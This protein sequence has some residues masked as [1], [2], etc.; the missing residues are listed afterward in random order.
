[1]SFEQKSTRM[2]AK[3]KLLPAFLLLLVVQAAQ[4]QEPGRIAGVVAAARSNE[5]LSGVT[6]VVVGTLYA[7]VTD[8]AGR[9]DVGPVPPGR[10]TVQV[11]ALGFRTEAQVV[12][13]AAGAQAV[14]DF[15]LRLPEVTPEDI[16]TV[17]LQ[18]GLLPL[19]GVDLRRIR[20]VNA[21]DAGYLLRLLHG[22]GAGRR[23]AI[24]LHPSIRGLA[25]NQIGLYVDGARLLP[26]SPVGLGAPL[27]FFDPRGLESV[28]AV[29]GPYALTW[30]AGNLGALW[31]ETRGEDPVA[32]PRASLT[33]GYTSNLDALDLAGAASGGLGLL[34]YWLQGVLRTGDD[35]RDGKGRRVPADF[36]AT[37]VRGRLGFRLAP[38]ARLGVTAGYQGRQHVDAPGRLLDARSAAAANVSARFRSGWSAGLLRALDATLYWNRLA[39]DLDN[40]NTPLG[41]TVRLLLD[42][43]HTQAG[44]RLAAHLAPAEGWWLEAG[45]DAYSARY[46]ATLRLPLRGD[47]TRRVLPDARLATLGVFLGGTRTFGRVE[48]AVTARL[49]VVRAA[50]E[51]FGDDDEAGFSAA[52]SLAARLS[53]IW[54]VSVGV[55]SAVRTADA[56]ERF[57]DRIPLR[58][59]HLVGEVSGNPALLPERSTQAD[60]WLEADYPRLDLRLGAF[61]R[62]LADHIIVAPFDT[63]DA[64][65]S[66]ALPLRYVNGEATFFGA[67]ATADYA[68]FRRYVTLF[69]Q[70]SFLWGRD[71]TLLEP[72][73]GVAPPAAALGGR[74]Q[75]PG[76]LFFLEGTLRAAAAQTRVAASRGETSTGGYLTA[77][78]RLGV[79]LPRSSSLLIGLDN[80]TGAAYADHLNAQHPFTLVRLAE[81]GF[82]FF[83]RLR[84]VI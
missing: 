13:V 22:V 51:G 19:A 3:A 48:A 65:G 21:L 33:A 78:L 53:A 40:E 50:A 46:D 20:E 84:L 54:T 60:L 30:G 49:D 8:T 82:T 24:D 77:D 27:G 66:E 69:A 64:P 37:D 32:R 45:A 72:A 29:K 25:E 57:A 42:A 35:Y 62:R 2:P 81:P 56:V 43:E 16:E 70:A 36:R 6:V 67:E 61:A 7:A 26:G 74:L 73:F 14:V 39:Q 12:A 28:E 9:F 63:P 34:S 83:A 18:R 76:N 68:V 71:E 10:Y 15:R 23:S 75:A 41:R 55:G 47:T 59:T 17:A 4:A 5:P 1:M 11:N 38:S 79:S 44:G 52:V 58:T 80:L 31:V